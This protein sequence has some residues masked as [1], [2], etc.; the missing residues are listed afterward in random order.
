MATSSRTTSQ[1]NWP[2]AANPTTHTRIHRPGTSRWCSSWW[3]TET[4][5]VGC[6]TRRRSDSSPGRC[7]D[8]VSLAPR[9]SCTSTAASPQ[10]YDP[11]T[12][13]DTSRLVLVSSLLSYSERLLR[14]NLESLG[15]RRVKAHLVLLFK[16]I[17]GFVDID[18]SAMFDI[19][20]DRT[21]GS[22]ST[23]SQMSF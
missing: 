21:T 16:L 9:R 3:E 4:F 13:S 22:W 10:T 8:S 18:W 7:E 11:K 2:I 15:S 5:G 19:Q 20:F 1:C 17:H 12:D 23:Y 14:L 6:G